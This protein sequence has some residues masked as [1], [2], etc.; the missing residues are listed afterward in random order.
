MHALTPT[1]RALRSLAASLVLAGVLVAI[2][3]TAAL[4][5]SCQSWGSG[6]QPPNMSS[7]NTLRGVANISP[8]SAWAVGYFRSGTV[9]QTRVDDPDQPE[10]GNR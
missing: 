7:D 4:A 5:S 10:R 8:C 1:R 3:S 6:I 9:Y 2:T